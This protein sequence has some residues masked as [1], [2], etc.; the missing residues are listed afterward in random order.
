VGEVT[1]EVRRGKV[2]GDNGVGEEAEVSETT[3]VER[4]AEEQAE[5]DLAYGLKR[6]CP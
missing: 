3:T 1:V 2:V 5:A 6:C 4:D